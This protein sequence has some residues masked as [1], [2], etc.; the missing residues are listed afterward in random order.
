MTKG[1]QIVG[2]MQQ[3]VSR[4]DDDSGYVR[5][6]YVLAQDSGD[7]VRIELPPLYTLD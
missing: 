4:Q 6:E 7:R 3:P 2:P 5:A 1:G